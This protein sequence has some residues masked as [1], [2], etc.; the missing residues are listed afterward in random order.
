VLIESESGV[1]RAGSIS[2]W[3]ASGI[4]CAVLLFFLLAPMFIGLGLA[5]NQVGALQDSVGRSADSLASAEVRNLLSRQ[6][7]RTTN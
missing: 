1:G 6:D 2:G 3:A 4:F 5:A 7:V